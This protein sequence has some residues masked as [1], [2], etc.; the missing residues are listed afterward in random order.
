MRKNKRAKTVVKAVFQE[1][2]RTYKIEGYAIDNKSMVIVCA[3]FNGVLIV[4]V[5]PIGGK[6]K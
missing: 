1:N 6:R 4:T 3:E 2:K 5:Y